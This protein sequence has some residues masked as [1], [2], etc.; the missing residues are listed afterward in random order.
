MKITAM[1]QRETYLDWNCGS[2]SG[3]TSTA[4]E[5]WFESRAPLPKQNKSSQNGNHHIDMLVYITQFSKLMGSLGCRPAGCLALLQELQY[6]ILFRTLFLLP[7]TYL[8]PQWICCCVM[9]LRCLLVFSNGRS[10]S[11]SKWTNNTNQMKSLINMILG[12]ATRSP[13]LA[14]LFR[15]S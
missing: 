15:F 13:D 7:S 6:S 8:Q 3:V 12:T 2:P 9:M 5:T 14:L 10:S 1:R 4:L 11:K